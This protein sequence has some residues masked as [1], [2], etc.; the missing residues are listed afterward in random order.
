MRTGFNGQSQSPVLKYPIGIITL[1]I[2]LGITA[3]H[4]INIP[5]NSI[6]AINLLAL[7]GLAF[8]FRYSKKAFLPVPHFTV[9]SLVFSFTFGML[10]QSLHYAPNQKLHYSNAIDS[11]IPEIKGVI[12]ER[13]KPN[14]YQERYYFEVTAI[15]KK[16]ATGRILLT[17]PKDSTYTHVY[18]GDSFIIIDNPLPI[19][20]PLN[21]HQFNYAGYM[22]KQSVFH[23]LKLKDN[24]IETGTVKKFDYY[25]GRLR[26]TLVQS[27]SVH[28]YSPQVQNTLDALL[29]GQRQDMDTA[30]NDAYKDAGVLHILAI[31]GL[32]FS[33]LF[34][35]LTVFF[36]PL[37]RFSKHG[38]LLCL[39]A[40][41]S[42]I[43]GFA[44][45]TGLSASVVRSVVMFTIISFAQFMNRDTNIY[46]SLFISML[47]LLIANPYFIFDAG[48][49]LSY[50]AVF[51][52]V[53][54]QPFYQ[55]V[56]MSKHKPLNYLSDTLLVSLA[57]QIGVL[58]LSL[59]Y[60]NRFPLLFLI[61]NLVVIPLSNVVLVLGLLVL[62]LNF[63][64]IDA[65]LVAGKALGFLVEVMNG[66]ISW[67]A[68]FEN[69]VIKEISFTL[70]LT[71][72][73][74]GA[75]ALL[76]FWFYKKS[77]KRT[78]AL[79]C[80]ILIF[81]CAYYITDRQHKNNE[82]LVIFNNRK[83]TV[84]AIKNHEQLTLISDDSLIRNTATI[85]AYARE[86]FNTTLITQPL[87]NMIW[88]NEKK[89]FIIDK[90]A[91]YSTNIK[92]DIL[93]LTQSPKINLE[94]IVHEIQPKEIVA[95]ATNYKRSIKL[96][97]ATCRKEKIPFHATAEK[98]SYTIK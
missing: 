56:A 88:Y 67:I 71:V 48:F 66:F 87:H 43:W 32:H 14:D 31:S 73:L 59:Y 6:Y 41:L 64:W 27:F 20:K 35:L 12:T 86:G 10:I 61:A 60:F 26:E 49:Q 92:P 62:I 78:M 46:N 42:I 19:A 80:A 69:L 34:Y 76:V 30:T 75:I 17:I 28:K 95:D 72:I 37:N 4:Y 54:L 85:R 5:P 65:A 33:V 79:L 22:E 7:T 89:I 18:P 45:I 91:A 50:L 9:S 15:N 23:Q 74:Y 8:A 68:S 52:I 38:K 96:W 97:E 90:D 40:V 2:V 47:V 21:P 44:F 93:I 1:F 77:Y 13:L 11:T 83:N 81:Q 94:R 70:L 51:A 57:A 29:L 55:Q 98:G 3:G 25:L 84:I 24:Y 58:P 39:I 36:K 82:E 16:K 63:I 53:L